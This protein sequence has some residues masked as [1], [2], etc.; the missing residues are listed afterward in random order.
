[1][2]V[3]DSGSTDGTLACLPAGAVVHRFVGEF[4]YSEAL[5]QGLRL[6]TQPYVLILSSHTSLGSPD[7]ME[8]ALALMEAR[9]EIGAAYFA[10]EN[11]SRIDHQII[12]KENFDGFN[13]LFNTCGVV[14][15]SLLAERAFRREVFTAEDQEWSQW[16]LGARDG[17]IARISGVGLVDG[18]PR[19][20]SIRKNANEY[21]SIAYFVRPDLLSWRNILNCVRSG[22][23][24]KARHG[25]RKRAFY[26]ILAARLVACRFFRPAPK[27]RY[28]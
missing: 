3:V 23:R 20:Y 12:S 16:Y 2:V 9:P 1:M 14:R 24:L 7:A 11:G 21:I 27:S 18:N 10:L 25:V 15:V 17:R 8:Y 4:N 6:V 13:G 19:R 26:L 28:F 5:N 22:M